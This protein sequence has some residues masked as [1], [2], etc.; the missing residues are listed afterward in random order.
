M[1]EDIVAG[2]AAPRRI[3]GAGAGRRADRVDRGPGSREPSGDGV[4]VGPAEEVRS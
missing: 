1:R 2:G 3:D 4:T